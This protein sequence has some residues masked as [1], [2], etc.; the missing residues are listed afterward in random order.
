MESI[1]A[2][3]ISLPEFET[4][5]R[6]L[7]TEVLIIGGGMTGLLCA[8][9]LQQE[10][11]PYILLEGKTICGG[12]TRN[13]TAKITSQHGL[14]YH[15]LLRKFG[16]SHTKMYY[17]A[18]EA[19]LERYR[20]LCGGLDC[21]FEAKANYVY[22]LDDPERLKQELA[23][24]KAI[25]CTKAE[26]KKALPLPFPTVGAV[27]MRRQAQFHPLRFVSAIAPELR[28]YEHSPVQKLTKHTAFTD[29]GSVTADKI[30]VAT[31]FP[32]LNKHGSYFLKMYQ[33]RSYVLALEGAPDPEGMYVD[34][35]GSGLSFRSC[36]G[37]LLLG[38]GGHRT[39]KRGGGWEELNDFAR[40]YYPQAKERAR[41]AT[42][43]CITLD[44]MPYIGRYS[45][46]TPDLLVA[47]GYNKWGMT[48][49]MVAASLLTDLIVG[50]E[51]PYT[52]LFS[53]SRSML[54]PQLAL[55]ALEAAAGLIS[56]ARG[57]CPHLGCVLR[58]NPQ[59]HSWDCPCHGSRFSRTGRLLDNP[60]NG[61]LPHPPKPP[62]S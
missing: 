14:I 22:S 20:K 3:E 46:Q 55:N 53:P 47:T 23:A 41:W 37:M 60:A 30:I 40:R 32:F 26:Y 54:H 10:N 6:D 38:G 7:K 13:T 57:R 62:A 9:L 28:L 51:N 48:T 21:G 12:V 24:L 17:E 49:S 61:D 27:G 44:G 33:Q 4:L 36:D 52:R 39:G 58:W 34:E 11:I 43:D 59:E 2:K 19:A 45:A 18:N 56:P 25:G 1:W 5:Q 35:A 8:H 31:H 42:Q 50:R 29:L 15:K 16:I